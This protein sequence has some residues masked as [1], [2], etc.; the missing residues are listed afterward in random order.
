MYHYKKY[1]FL[2]SEPKK[3]VTDSYEGKRKDIE[4]W[5]VF[6]WYQPI[7]PDVYI[8]NED[9]EKNVQSKIENNKN[10]LEEEKKS[11][12]QR[13]DNLKKEYEETKA[14]YDKDHNERVAYITSKMKKHESM[15]LWVQ[16]ALW[17]NKKSNTS[18]KKSK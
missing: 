16:K 10:S 1:V 11:E 3:I 15:L 7:W 2:G 4:P 9:L 12:K 14:K 18:S 17:K 13:Q 5:T 8:L 6:E